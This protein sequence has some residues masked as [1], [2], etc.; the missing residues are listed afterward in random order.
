M[1]SPSDGSETGP[2][3]CYNAVHSYELGWYETHDAP[4]NSQ[5]VLHASPFYGSGTGA[6]GFV[7]KVIG[8]YQQTDVYVGYNDDTG[9]NSNTGECLDQL[10]VHTWAGS[11]N[12][13][14]RC[15]LNVGQECT[16]EGV[17]VKFDY[18]ALG[19]ITA[20]VGNLS[21]P[22][23]SPSPSP[24]KNPTVAPTVGPT[25]APPPV[26]SGTCVGNCDGHAS[27]CWCDGYC[28]E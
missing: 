14:Q 25:T 23:P 3:R 15:C 20:T 18:K 6:D 7:A 24:P 12:T 4:L 5:F 17:N 26:F 28:M 2:F 22:T 1:G 13:E 21:G 9:L 19:L 8:T 16:V 27:D 10:T 11:G